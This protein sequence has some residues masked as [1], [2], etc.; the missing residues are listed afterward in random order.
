MLLQNM[1]EVVGTYL[2][3]Y[4]PT[5]LFSHA[6]QQLVPSSPAWFLGGGGE[7]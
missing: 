4:L 7:I 1:E 3:T 6:T 5:Y 2:P